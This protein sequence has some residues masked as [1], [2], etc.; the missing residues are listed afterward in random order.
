MALYIT[1][2]ECDTRYNMAG[3]IPSD[4]ES[5]I[6]CAT[7]GANTKITPSKGY[8]ST[9]YKTEVTKKRDIK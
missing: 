5:T 4:R 7:C 1:C 2:T 9:S 6:V 8:F 3:K